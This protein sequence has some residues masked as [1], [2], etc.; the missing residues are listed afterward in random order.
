MEK[1][2]YIYDEKGNPSSQSFSVDEIKKKSLKPSTIICP[3][4]GEPDQMKNFPELF[5]SN[6]WQ[7]PKLDEKSRFSIL[8][9]KAR[10]ILVAS[11][12]AVAVGGGTYYA[13]DKASSTAKENAKQKEE[14]LQSEQQIQKSIDSLETVNSNFRRQIAPLTAGVPENANAISRLQ[15][16]K[17]YLAGQIVYLESEKKKNEKLSAD[18][19]READGWDCVMDCDKAARQASSD[20]LDAVSSNQK[21]IV[22]YTTEIADIDNVRMPRIR[23]EQETHRDNITQFSQAI[24]ANTAKIEALTSKKQNMATLIKEDKKK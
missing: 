5:T 18:K 1:T 17:N 7:P 24:E 3:E 6:E 21:S 8:G 23:S 11:S 15:E 10:G 12:M 14:L 13:A 22:E 20:Y 9:S 4:F 2:Y 16:R 19:L